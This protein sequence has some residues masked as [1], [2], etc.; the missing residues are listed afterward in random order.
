MHA[1]TNLFIAMRLYGKDWKKVE[2]HIGTRSGAQIRSH[3]QKFFN[4][5][6][7]ELG[8]DVDAFLNSKA[9]KTSD[10]EQMVNGSEFSNVV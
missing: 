9:S 5:V 3:A 6:E 1:I 8:T 4:R 10:S 2:Q 7:K